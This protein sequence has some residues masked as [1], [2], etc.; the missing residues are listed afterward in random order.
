MLKHYNSSLLYF[1]KLQLPDELAFNKQ[2][3]TKQ[4]HTSLYVAASSNTNLP[5]LFGKEVSS[6]FQEYDIH[7]TIQDCDRSPFKRMDFNIL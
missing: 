5:I 6:Y 2:K 7:H 4:T 1:Y 3:L